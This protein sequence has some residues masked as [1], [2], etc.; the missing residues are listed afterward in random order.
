MC[1][2]AN[3]TPVADNFKNHLDDE[4]SRPDFPRAEAE[5]DFVRGQEIYSL[6]FSSLRRRCQRFFFCLFCL[7]GKLR[8]ARSRVS[9]LAILNACGPAGT[10]RA[11]GRLHTAP[12]SNPMRFPVPHT[13][14]QLDR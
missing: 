4:F 6:A 7:V 2:I 12:E 3:D 10:D 1:L 8:L 13:V 9:S 11:T 14:G 5:P